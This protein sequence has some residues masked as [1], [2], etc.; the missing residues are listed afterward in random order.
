MKRELEFPFTIQNLQRR[1]GHSAWKA[2]EDK[3]KS[4]VFKRGPNIYILIRPGN[5]PSSWPT[6]AV[7]LSPAGELL[8][9][10]Q[11]L[12]TGSN[13]RPRL[14]PDVW[15]LVARENLP[16]GPP[17]AGGDCF[18]GL[19]LCR[20]ES[21]LAHTLIFVCVVTLEFVLLSIMAL[22]HK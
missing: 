12:C 10:K 14:G 5:R 7:T 1:E 22:L 19:K 2:Q 21:A 20:D 15:Y 9:P 6:V 4:Y 3:R 18:G 13:S 8:G 16:P 11:A 17:H